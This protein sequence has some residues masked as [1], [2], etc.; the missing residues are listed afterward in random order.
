[1]AKRIQAVE[2]AIRRTF[3]AET[4]VVSVTEDVELEENG[5]VK[6]YYVYGLRLIGRE[7]AQGEYL[8]YHADMRGFTTLLTDKYGKVTDRYTNGLYG[9]LES[10]EGRT[11]QPFCYNGPRWGYDRPEWVLL[12]AGAVLPPGVEAI[13]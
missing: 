3:D 13:P 9:E 7:D 5:A 8:S 2:D 1:M 6:A 12:Y 10:H 11:K 4:R